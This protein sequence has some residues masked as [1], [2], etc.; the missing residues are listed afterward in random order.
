VHVAS[1][2][3]Y[4]FEAALLEDLVEGNPVDPGRFHRHGLHPAL[5]QPLCQ[6]LQIGGKGAELADRLGVAFGRH[7]YEMTLLSAIDAGGIGLD[8]FEQRD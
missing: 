2:D 7:R 5:R 6:A 3:Q 1:I 8:A 4:H